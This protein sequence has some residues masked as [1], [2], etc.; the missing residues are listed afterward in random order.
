MTHYDP[1]TIYQSQEFQQELAIQR[2]FMARVFGWMTI[3]LLVTAVTAFALDSAHSVQQALLGNTGIVITLLVVQ[4]GVALAFGFLLNKIPAAVAAALFLVYSLITGAVCSSIFLV[5]QLSTIYSAFFI[6]AGT[7][8]GMAIF[9]YVTKRDLTGL[10][11]LCF[12]ALW[13]IILATIVNFFVGST[14]LAWL[15]NY[16][17]VLIF[18]GLTAYDVQKFK[19]LYAAG[20]AGSRVFNRTAIWGAFELY[21]DFINLFLFILRILGSRRN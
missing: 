9:G 15:I 14:S 8:G 13:G 6:T 3:G 2:T 21:L 20:P 4:L 7:F 11:S 17:G 10:G 18:V 1:A 19:R 16:A 12:M 5:Y